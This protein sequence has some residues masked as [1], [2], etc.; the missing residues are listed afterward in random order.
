LATPALHQT[1]RGDGGTIFHGTYLLLKNCFLVLALMLNAKKSASACQI[2]RDL[3]MRRPTV[4]SMMHRIR[5]A[6]ASAIF[7]QELLFGIVEADETYVGGKPQKGNNPGDNYRPKVKRERGTSKVFPSWILITLP[8]YAQ[9]EENK[10]GMLR[11]R[12]NK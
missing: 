5:N 8:N 6:M 10:K 2:A 12:N 9:L 3:G 1:F 4:W 7:Q 11:G